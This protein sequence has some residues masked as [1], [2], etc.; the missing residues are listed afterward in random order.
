MFGVEG[1][2]QKYQPEFNKVDMFNDTA[3]L[4]A[5]HDYSKQDSLS[6]YLALSKAQAEY[7]KE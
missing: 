4:E 5:F 3:L 6:L 7:I 2:S 1:K